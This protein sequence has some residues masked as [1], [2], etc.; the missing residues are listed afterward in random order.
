MQQAAKNVTDSIANLNRIVGYKQKERTE[1]ACDLYGK[2]LAN[3]LRKLSE[4]DRMQ[5]MHEIDGLYLKKM[6]QSENIFRPTSTNVSL[7]PYSP[8]PMVRFPAPTSYVQS[9]YPSPRELNSSCSSY[10]ESTLL[11]LQPRRPSS[12]YSFSSGSAHTSTPPVIEIPETI[13]ISAIAQNIYSPSQEMAASNP[14]NVLCDEIVAS[15]SQ[16]TGQHS[17]IISEAYNKAMN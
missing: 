6:S 4:I 16:T 7:Y 15:T 5:L 1:D 13:E 11:E 3:K 17:S 8:R 2:L 10:S 12:S 14:V 9:P